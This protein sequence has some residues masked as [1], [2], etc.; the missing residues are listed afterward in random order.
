MNPKYDVYVQLPG[1]DKWVFVTSTDSD[2]GDIAD[3]CKVLFPTMTGLMV[4]PF[5][6][7][8]EVND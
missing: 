3:A 1:D 7:W 5:E 2:I 8:E 4:N 6:P